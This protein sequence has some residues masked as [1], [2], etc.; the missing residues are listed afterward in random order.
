[1]TLRA[2]LLLAVVVG[3][4]VFVGYAAYATAVM[5]GWGERTRVA[6]PPGMERHFRVGDT[7]M[8]GMQPCRVGRVAAGELWVS[9]PL[10]WRAWRWVT[11]W[12]R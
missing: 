9:R 1:M 2:G 4:A 11:R 12:R 8:A 5:M 3:A 6:I 10:W 7:V